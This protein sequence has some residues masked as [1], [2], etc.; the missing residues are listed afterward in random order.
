QGALR[1]GYR[2]SKGEITASYFRGYDDAARLTAIPGLPD[3]VTGIVPVTLDRSFPRLNVAGLDGELLFGAWIVRGE[4]GY[5][6]YPDG[7]AGYFLYPVEGGWT[8][9]A[10][11]AIAG[12]G[13]TAGGGS[14]AVAA[15]SLDAAYLP[16][17]FLGGTYGEATE[18]RVDVSATVG[19]RD[20]NSFV[21][22]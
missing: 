4:A 18:W 13:G 19:T 1:G 12:Y 21:R 15:T 16:A 5:F 20:W 14:V 22:I 10:W 17:I 11:R 7:E 9:G 3:P 2:G 8:R 6:H